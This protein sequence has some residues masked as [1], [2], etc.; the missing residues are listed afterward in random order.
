M[1]RMYRDPGTTTRFYSGSVLVTRGHW[2]CDRT[3]PGPT[4]VLV[5]VVVGIPSLT[6]T[7]LVSDS[8][9]IRIRL[10]SY[11]RDD[12]VFTVLVITP[13]HGASASLRSL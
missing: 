12:S 13:S 3:T 8:R 7:V 9:R 6:R 4:V 2:H 5:L 10:S 1:T 11:Y